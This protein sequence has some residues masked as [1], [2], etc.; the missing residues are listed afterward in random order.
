MEHIK[1]QSES[2][3]R[4]ARSIEIFNAE[5]VKYINNF[6]GIFPDPNL[7]LCTIDLIP[8][9]YNRKLPTKTQS[10]N[11][12]TEIDI[13]FAL[14]DLSQPTLDYFKNTLNKKKFAVVIN[15]NT[16]KLLL[17]N[18]REPL[19]IEVIDNIKDDNSGTDEYTIALSGDSIITPKIQTL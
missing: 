1:N 12:F 19:K 9:S 18:E 8:E 3:Y 10:S 17:G 2:F 5:D 4:E 14:V 13:N 7:A 15:S 16:E 6:N 11:Y